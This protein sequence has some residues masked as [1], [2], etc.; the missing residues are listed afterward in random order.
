[1]GFVYM[2]TL[3]TYSVISE[4]KPPDVREIRFIPVSKNVD[5]GDIRTSAKVLQR[6]I[7]EYGYAGIEVKVVEPRDFIKDISILMEKDPEPLVRGKAAIA[8]AKLNATKYTKDIVKLLEDENVDAKR[9]AIK[10][11]GIMGDKDYANEVLKFLKGNDPSLVVSAT[12]AIANMGLT[13]YAKDLSVLLE[14]ED[15]KVKAMACLAL[16]MLRLREFDNDILILLASSDKYVKSSAVL[17]CGY[18]GIEKVKEK[19]AEMLNNPSAY[20]RCA[21]IKSLGRLKAKE[22]LDSIQK[23]LND[24]GKCS[25]FNETIKDFEMVTVGSVAK[26]VLTSFDSNNNKFRSLQ[27]DEKRVRELVRDLSTGSDEKKIASLTQLATYQDSEDYADDIALLLMP[28]ENP[29][30]VGSAALTLA[31]LGIKKY[32]EEI[33]DLLDSSDQYIRQSAI[34]ALS[35]MGVNYEPSL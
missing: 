22:F 30:V 29:L 4:Y 15:N 27:E 25:M 18:L 19:L 2:I 5:S 6:R 32:F 35:I 3:L 14:H 7:K 10:A 16:G 26:E 13:K 33:N 9:L 17:A 21:A 1:M 31:K 23:L 12:I 20:V 8:L 24:P 11:L 34:E 28:D